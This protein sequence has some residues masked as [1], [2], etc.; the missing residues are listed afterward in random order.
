[1]Q[2]YES[3]ASTHDVI[4]HELEAIGSPILSL[5]IPCPSVAT[6]GEKWRILAKTYEQTLR[7]RGQL[8]DRAA[9]FIAQLSLKDF[10]GQGIALFVGPEGMRSLQLNRRPRAAMYRGEHPFLLPVLAD[11]ARRSSEWVLALNKDAPKLFFYANGEAVDLSDRLDGPSYDDIEQR[12]HVQDDVF[13][14]A[15]R[16]GGAPSATAA[17]VF[18]ALGSGVG[19]EREKTD[20]QFYLATAKAVL[21]ALPPQTDHLLVMGDPKTVGRFIEQFPSTDFELNSLEG[22]GDA[23]T[24]EGI[25][26]RLS[27][28]VL[29][30]IDLPEG[31]DDEAVIAQAVETGRVERFYLKDSVSLLE[32][33]SSG[34]SEH[35]DLV[36]IAASHSDLLRLNTLTLM[37]LSHG[38]GLVWR[39]A[40]ATDS[41]KAP[42][43]AA[44]RWEK[45]VAE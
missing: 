3:T 2:R 20:D 8:E 21:A 25:A 42:A 27:E 35:V 1:M 34:E 12:R 18:H 37:A 5:L 10:A 29:P 14:H 11:T 26:T 39:P 23:Q 16:R 38:A 22:A 33:R 36:D 7:G 28:H 44:M 13:F 31:T 19:L 45:N 41:S 24:A 4:R 15:G 32:S 30:A 43:F 6:F 40:S 17:S 9:D